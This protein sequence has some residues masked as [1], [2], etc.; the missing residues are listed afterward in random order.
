MNE[1]VNGRL[2]VF[3]WPCNE[4]ATHSRC[5]LPSPNDTWDRFH[6]TPVTLSLMIKRVK[7][8]DGWSWFVKMAS[9]KGQF[10]VSLFVSVEF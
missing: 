9:F 7:K 1:R 10:G 2:S 5:A 4:V 8:L 6:L 3:L